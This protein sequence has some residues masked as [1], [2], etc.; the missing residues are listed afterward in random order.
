MR[1]LIHA[2]WTKFRTVRGWVVGMLV[3]VVLTVLVGM[4]GPAGSQLSCQGPNGQAC[5]NNTPPTGPDGTSVNDAFYFVRR[6][7][8][9]DGAITARVAPLAGAEPWAK[10]GLIVKDGPA[11][12]SPY[13]A[14]ARTGAHGVHMQHNYT[15][16]TAGQDTAWLRLS[17]KGNTL[18]GAT[19]PDGERWTTISTVTLSGLPRTVQAGLFVTSPEHTEVTRTFGGVD[20]SGGP[21]LATGAFDRV[22]VTGDW[23]PRWTGVE[24]GGPTGMDTGFTEADG[25]FTVRGTGDIAPVVPS[26]G[27]IGRTVESSLVGV[28]AGLIAVLVVATMFVT[29]EHRRGLIRTSLAASPRRGQLLAAKAVV[30]GSVAFVTGVVAAAAA[31]PLVGWLVRAKGLYF[32]PVST[33][34][35][36]RVIAGTGA[37]F[38]V[39]SVLALAVGTLLRRGAGTVTSVVV[40]IVLPYLLAVAQ[41]LPTGSAQ[42]LTRLTP[43]A[44]FAVQQ[45]TPEYPQVNASYT[46]AD[47]YFPLS[48]AGGFAVLCAYAV[49]AVALATVALRRR[50]V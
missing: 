32:Y 29:A 48:P 23:S 10:A 21:S 11:A 28:F 25:R 13:A 31:I 15:A 47:G 50:D 1:H 19:S 7:L 17:R 39:A 8:T 46:P 18:T 14:V 4:L 43:A 2:E 44:A 22:L 40:G 5:V 20:A 49:V 24:Q 38:A 12:G 34:T 3:A 9:G 37:L 36:V 45:S 26:Q 6:A 33:A 30:I 41:V 42:W 16:D 27:G 35:E